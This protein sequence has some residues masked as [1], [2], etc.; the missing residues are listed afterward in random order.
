MLSSLARTRRVAGAALA[1]SA[2]VATVSGCQDNAPGVQ[3]PSSPQGSTQP[4]GTQAPATSQAPTADPTQ[5][6]TTEPTQAPTS[7][8]GSTALTPDGTRLKMGQEGIVED[9]I[10]SEHKPIGITPTSMEKAPDSIFSSVPSL[11]RARG[12]V[13]FVKHD[14]RNVQSVSIDGS[15]INGYFFYPRTTSATT[16]GGRIYATVPGCEVHRDPIQPGQKASSCFAYQIADGDPTEIVYSKS[17]GTIT[18]TK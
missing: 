12:P 8:S 16:G 11:N 14:V 15:D 18:W 13:Y 17:S 6:P 3:Q 10:G 4:T 2:V 5:A 7:A 1:L 9:G